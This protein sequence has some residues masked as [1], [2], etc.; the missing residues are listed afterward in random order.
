MIHINQPGNKGGNADFL[1]GFFAF[2]AI[3]M[4]ASG[5]PERGQRFA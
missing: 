1:L 5:Y 3:K 4:T 2:F